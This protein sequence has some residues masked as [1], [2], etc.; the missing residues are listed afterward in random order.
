MASHGT[1]LTQ[2]GR[3]GGLA[4]SPVRPWWPHRGATREARVLASGQTSQGQLGVC[5]YAGAPLRDRRCCGRVAAHSLRRRSCGQNDSSCCTSGQ[6]S[7]GSS[8]TAAACCIMGSPPRSTE[9]D[10]AGAEALAKALAQLLFRRHGHRG[11]GTGLQGSLAALG[12]RSRGHS[13]GT[14][15]C[16][17][18]VA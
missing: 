12:M 2:H 16:S 6:A 18:P 15:R 9:V 17:W 13:P 7:T 5:R 10:T 14:T 4:D 3:V 11:F 8:R 1:Q